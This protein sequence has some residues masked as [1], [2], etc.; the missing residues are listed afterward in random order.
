M[1][2]SLALSSILSLSLFYLS[3]TF[4]GPCP[5]FSSLPQSWLTGL[6]Q[7]GETHTHIHTQTCSLSLTHT[8]TQTQSLPHTHTLRLQSDTADKHE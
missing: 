3:S 5:S 4:F 7:N 8:H 1:S 6:G 2:D